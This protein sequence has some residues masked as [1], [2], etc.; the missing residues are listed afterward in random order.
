MRLLILTHE[1]S[2]G[3]SLLNW[4]E[5]ELALNSYH[6]PFNTNI[7]PVDILTRENIIV[8]EFPHNIEIWC[9]IS[10]DEFISTFDYVIVL[11]R[12]NTYEAAISSVFMGSKERGIEHAHTIYTMN[13]EWIEKYESDIL[14]KQKELDSKIEILKN[15]PNG[16]QVTYERIYEN[17]DDI[18]KIYQYVGLKFIEHRDMLNNK[19]R[20]RNGEIEI[21][22]FSHYKRHKNLI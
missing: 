15:I 22:K 1:R 8:K 12:E 7:G 11:T 19:Y 13:V 10:L 6:E 2:G 3:M 20:L 4:L 17:T 18:K 5:I 21:P 16:L 14:I 9:T